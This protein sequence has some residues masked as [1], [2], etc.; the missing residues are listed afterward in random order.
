MLTLLATLLIL[1]PVAGAQARASGQEDDILRDRLDNGLEVVVVRNTLSP[2]ATTVVSYMAGA[3]ESPKGFPGTAHALEHMMFRGSPGLSA[4]QLA[5]IMA[6]M[7]GMFNALTR[8]NATQYFLTVPSEDLE[9]ALR[10][11]AA[12]MRGV[13][14][15]E[16]QWEQE[17]GAM[18]QE[19]ARNLSSPEYVFYTRLREALFRGTPYEQDALGTR[20][21]LQKTTVAMLKRFHDDWYVPGNA[22]LVVAGDV[23]PAETL[24]TVRKLFGDIPPGKVPDRPDVKLKPVEKQTI[25]LRTDKPYGSVVAAFRMPGFESPD[26]AAA[27]VLSDIL[28]NPRGSLY[29]LVPGGKALDTGFQ[30]DAYPKA[31][32][33]YT[34]ALFPEGADAQ[35]LEKELKKVLSSLVKDGVTGD[36][37]EAARRR[38]MTDAELEKNS[39]TGLAMAWSTAL[40]VEGRRSPEEILDAIGKVGVED[41]NRVVRRYIDPNRMVTGILMPEPS[42][43]PVPSEG[44][45]GAESF[46]PENISP[47]KLPAWAEKSLRKLRVP[48]S[49]LN[50]VVNMLPNGLR[51]IVQPVSVSD[52]VS[53][54]GHVRNTPELQVPEGKEGVDQVLASLFSYGTTTLDREEFQ[55]SLDE[56]GAYASAG[57]DFTLQVL[58][59]HADRGIELLADNVINPAL[60]ERDFE[61]V[62]RQAAAAAAGRLESPE[63]LAE[64]A[65]RKALYPEGDPTLRQATPETLSAL[66]I[67]DVWR[68]YRAVFRPDMTTVVVIGRITPERARALIEEHF[69]A[70]KAPE[71]PKPDVLLSPVPLNGPSSTR[72]PNASRVQDSVVL[73]QT[74]GMTRSHPDYYALQLGNHV[75]GGAFYATRLY[76]D[77]RERTGLVYHV[78][79]YF[80]V[81]QTRGRYV[82]EYACDPSNTARARAIVKRNLEDMQNNPVSPEEL[83]RAKALLLRKIPLSES[84]ISG[85]ARGFIHRIR[86]DLPLDEPTRAAHRYLALD[87]RQVRD[88][89]A[90]WVRVDDLA[91]VIEGPGAP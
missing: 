1:T 90:R 80:D 79:S 77:L 16:E 51:L 91:E 12:R 82:V 43:K 37:V 13:L 86:L 29:A 4:G 65:V 74:L 27:R 40:A 49:A 87:A 20:E 25:R 63:Y 2:V 61:T 53:V 88:A 52:T 60:P 76:R 48:P 44:F 6:A 67:D 71:R 11:E 70:W 81:D 17:R 39:V 57:T 84:S 59:E 73:A 68:H 58:S 21:S 35:A 26:Y 56:I 83:L 62:R 66:S 8:Q 18:L 36:M 47:V 41:V 64:R 54:Y 89:F 24:A 50:P 3:D 31:G 23:R 14:S 33:G 38:T 32:L 10:I 55:R 45:G 75:L 19:V 28:N 46:T 22:V 15:G 5:N 78:S 7:G 85:V 72:V 9:V 34:V 69:G 42:G 30:L